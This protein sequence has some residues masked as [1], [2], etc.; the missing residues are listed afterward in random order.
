VKSA[1]ESACSKSTWAYIGAMICEGVASGISSNSGKI[2][3][4]AQS[5]A[6]K[7]YNAAKSE[8]GINS[9]SKSFAELGMYCM[10]GLVVGIEDNS[11][12]FINAYRHV[13]DNAKRYAADSD[14]LNAA[15]D[16]MRIAF[17]AQTSVGDDGD[18]PK[19]GGIDYTELARAVW[20]EMPEDFAINQTVN[21]NQP[22]KTPDETARELRYNN[23]Q[24]LVGGNH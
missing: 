10:E 13:L 11:D 6:R 8:L 24:G 19:R 17:D 23:T 9:P 15:A 21:F 20:E 7:A 22:V 18:D 12:D 16:R 14:I 2:A 1:L 4:A 3:S 5:A